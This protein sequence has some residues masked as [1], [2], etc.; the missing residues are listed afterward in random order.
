MRIVIEAHETVTGMTDLGKE[1]FAL[2]DIRGL[3]ECA[4]CVK[5]LAD[6]AYRAAVKCLIENNGKTGGQIDGNH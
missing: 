2:W 3:V 1:G 4:D 6:A 5:P